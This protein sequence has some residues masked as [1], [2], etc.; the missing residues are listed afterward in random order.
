MRS[1]PARIDLLDPHLADLAGLPT[2]IAERSVDVLVVGA[3]PAGLAA[4]ETAAGHGA[5]VTVLDERA[6]PG[7]QFY[8]QRQG[9]AARDGQMQEGARLIERVRGLGVAIRG[10]TLVWGAERDKDGR[11]VLGT[12]CRG[13]AARWRPR[14][15]VV[16]TGAFE[17]PLALPGWT[18]PGVMTTGGAQTLIRSYGVSAGQRVLVAGNGPLNLQVALELASAGSTVASVLDRAPPPHTRPREAG[19]LVI[20]HPALALA[21]MRQMARLRAS[22]I[23]LSW[24]SQLVRVE[25]G[26][27]VEAA[28]YATPE[29]E[30]RVA[31]DAVVV[32]NGF[33]SANELS[34][35]LGCAH[36]DR[37]GRLEV[38]RDET[39]RTSS[40]TSS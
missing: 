28:V 39:G 37:G 11:L 27:R 12:L 35:L 30:R 34:R 25:G 13:E 15:L 33:A 26:G 6:S 8:K 7:G 3:G 36:R 1:H 23:P 20:S 9:M 19:R 22:N 2:Q 10:E 17:T 18:L 32:G 31:V 40:P 5:S 38:E 14:V 29:G 4:A 24:S 21:G 16:A